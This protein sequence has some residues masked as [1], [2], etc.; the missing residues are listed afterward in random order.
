MGAGT[1]R[2]KLACESF[3]YK[4]LHGGRMANILCH[5]K[6][7]CGR[8]LKVLFGHGSR[9]HSRTNVAA[10]HL[11]CLIRSHDEEG[12]KSLKLLLLNPLQAK[13]YDSQFESILLGKK[14]FIPEHH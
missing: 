7:E 11:Q 6:C 1:R 2:L 10:S 4:I 8:K 12:L 13:I 9:A 14:S 5:V 3:I